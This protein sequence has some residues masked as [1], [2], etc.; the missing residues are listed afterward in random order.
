MKVIKEMAAKV[1]E[2]HARQLADIKS[3]E[4]RTKDFL[5]GGNGI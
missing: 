5:E 4:T 1:E 3:L 2:Q